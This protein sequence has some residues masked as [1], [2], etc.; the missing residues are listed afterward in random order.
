MSLGSLAGAGS[1]AQAGTSTLPEA[2]T[3]GGQEIATASNTFNLSTPE[4]VNAFT[5]AK[6][7][8][9]LNQAGLFF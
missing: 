8:P 7:F 4:G 3:E 2:L 1:A 9:Q 5:K 6:L